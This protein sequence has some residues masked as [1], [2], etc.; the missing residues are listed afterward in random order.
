MSEQTLQDVAGWMDDLRSEDASTRKTAATAIL[1]LATQA[2]PAPAPRGDDPALIV[3]LT[4]LQ[5][6]VDDL[7]KTLEGLPKTSLLSTQFLVRAF[8]VWGHL[9][10]AQLILAI[11]FAIFV[12]AMLMDTASR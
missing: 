12:F 5:G 3:K 2:Q 8:T 7:R 10:V 6:Q 9:F 1:R 11:P 4:A